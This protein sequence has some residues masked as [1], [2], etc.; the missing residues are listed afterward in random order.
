MT[1]TMSLI[2]WLIVDN[3]L[4]AIYTSWVDNNRVQNHFYDIIVAKYN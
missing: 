2:I 1:M 3:A 4:P